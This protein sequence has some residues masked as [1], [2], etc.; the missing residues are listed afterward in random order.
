MIDKNISVKYTWHIIR[1]V[2]NVNTTYSDH[3]SQIYSP[4]SCI[5]AVIRDRTLTTSPAVTFQTIYRI[6]TA[7]V[8][9]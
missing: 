4:L 6:S 5:F 8:S 7:K 9:I 2:E 3:T 1:P